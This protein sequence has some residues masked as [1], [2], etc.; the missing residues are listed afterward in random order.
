M[1]NNVD[2]SL[3]EKRG[4]KKEPQTWTNTHPDVGHK[5]LMSDAT[6]KTGASWIDRMLIPIEIGDKGNSANMKMKLLEG[7]MANSSTV[8]IPH[9][10]DGSVINVS[11]QIWNSSSGFFHNTQDEHGFTEDGKI[12]LTGVDADF[13]N[14]PYRIV[15]FYVP[16][17]EGD[18]VK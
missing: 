17:S 15:V 8:T 9:G 18:D 3:I 16:K 6:S 14:Q 11:V 7:T 5:V 13:R 12:K 4:K 10:C 2:K 1:I